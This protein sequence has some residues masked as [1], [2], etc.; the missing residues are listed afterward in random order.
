MHR[1]LL[2]SI[3][4]VMAAS[5]CVRADDAEKAEAKVEFDGLKNELDGVET[6]VGALVAKDT[7]G[8]NAVVKRLNKVVQVLVGS[9]HKALPEWVATFKRSVA[10]EDRAL[11]IV[12][13][14]KPVHAPDDR[15]KKG[16]DA[17]AAVE[18][19]HETQPAGDR[20]AATRLA[21][22]LGREA[23]SAFVGASTSAKKS[24]EWIES[25][26]RLHA[27]EAKIKAR[28]LQGHV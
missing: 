7:K 25:Y 26:S 8:G 5:P 15:T 12:K 20:A 13:G 9:R 4:V 28:N 23:K 16:I 11:E 18:K 10:L 24:N 6:D 19:A 1:A 17:L 21:N 22:D 27:L 3:V 14:E 2:A